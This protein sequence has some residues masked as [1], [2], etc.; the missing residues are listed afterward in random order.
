MGQ[1]IQYEPITKYRKFGVP[2]TYP[3][4][5]S[6]EK[7]SLVRE[8]WRVAGRELMGPTGR[9]RV[10]RMNDDGNLS[11]L[12]PKKGGQQARTA[13]PRSVVNYGER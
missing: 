2:V 5:Q 8:S 10:G 4:E 12:A 9:T 3:G 11:L 7:V 13:R 6:T 1:D